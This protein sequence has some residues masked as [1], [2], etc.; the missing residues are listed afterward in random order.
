M[1]EIIA[2]YILDLFEHRLAFDFAEALCN[3]HFNA[4]QIHSHIPPIPAHQLGVERGK[5]QTVTIPIL[6]HVFVAKDA[7]VS[8]AKCGRVPETYGSWYL[9][10]NHQ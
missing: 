7:L 3:D 2:D 10:G 8:I 4:S 5:P 9:D 6:V 1:L